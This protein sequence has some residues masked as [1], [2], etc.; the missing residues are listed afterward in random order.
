M[1]SEVVRDYYDEVAQK[2]WSRFDHPHYRLELVSTL[3][4]IEKY[5]PPAGHICDIGSGP[6]RYAI[7]L[8]KRGYR[9]TLFDLSQKS[10]D[11]ARGK[12][13]ESGL[14]A[15]AFICADA[16]DLSHLDDASF[17]AVL[18]LGPMY[19]VIQKK[20]RTHILRETRRILKESGIAMVAYINTWGVIRA[21]LTEFP[22]HLT[23]MTFMQALLDE[24]VREGAGLPGGF[25]EAY[26][27]T[28]PVAILEVEAAGFT[29][30]S[31]AGCEG[32]AAG[33]KPV[34]ADLAANKP[35]VYENLLQIVP[36][37]CEL[38]QYRD[39]TEHLHLVVRKG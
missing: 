3:Y 35:E 36:E 25:T 22:E 7:E 31:Y 2:E 5:F 11:I 9:V 30:V 32:F 34:V 29:L 8:L 26:F 16:R 38:E 6:G 15:E 1:M 14:Q 39:A 21:G 10:L 20:D 28:P 23:D 18:L 13:E 27:T 37:T 24:F 17:D 12:I 19:H 4:L 33:M